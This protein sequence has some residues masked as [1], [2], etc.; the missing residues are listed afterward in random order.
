MAEPLHW[1]PFETCRL[2]GHD[3][4][5]ASTAELAAAMV[6]DCATRGGRPR[7]VVDVNGQGVALRD[8]NPDYRSAV[9]AADVV[10]ADGQ[11]LVLL[12]RWLTRKPI[13]ERSATTD[14]IH[15]CAS[16]AAE[17]GLSFY[18]LGGEPGLSD[19]AADALTR[20]YPRL[21][22]VGH[23]HGFFGPNEEPALIEAINKAAPDVLWVGLGKPK[24]QMLALR[25]GDRL[26]CGWV[27]TCGG[28]FN[29]LTGDYARAPQWM[30]NFGLEWLFRALSS[31][32][33]FWRYPVTNPQALWIT[34]RE[35]AGG[36]R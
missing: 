35:L 9:D 19:K 28:C 2:A 3:I 5:T 17:R 26:T 24:E 36:R 27:V 11:F 10:H 23:H 7:I 31:R 30:Q 25:W 14:L 4:V 8:S 32:K 1:T 15:A 12:S 20:L 34:V 16:E 33:L 6:K 22:I 18:L 13:A 21:N 29:F